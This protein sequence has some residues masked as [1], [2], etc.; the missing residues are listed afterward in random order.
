MTSQGWPESNPVSSID[1]AGTGVPV[2]SRHSTPARAA[3]GASGAA[4]VGATATLAWL[5]CG[6]D[7]VPPPGAA[8]FDEVA[9]ALRITGDWRW[10]HDSTADG[11]RRRERERW[12]LDRVSLT[13]LRGS[14]LRDVEIELLADDGLVFAC[15][16]RVSY[17][18]QAR[19]DVVGAV[20]ADG[21]EL[22]EVG[23]QVT[24]SP[25]D[26]GLRALGHYH[27]HVDHRGQLVLL[28]DASVA[29][30]T[31]GDGAPPPPPPAIAT[32]LDGAWT[33]SSA[34][35]TADG[36]IQRELERWQLEVHGG[37]VTGSYQRVVTMVR[38]DGVALPCAGADRYQFVDEYQL[39]GTATADGWRLREDAVVAGQHPCLSGYRT[40]TLDEATAALDGEYLIVTWRGPRRQVLARVS[41]TW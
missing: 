31:A 29:R 12:Q 6:P 34:S 30:L 32:T 1:R 2:R 39:V 10:A 8:S 18:Q 23:Y 4:L 22:D 26:P 33:W 40:R 7:P 41:Q 14:Y 17:H 19:F 25:C 5:G 11:S 9:A 28:G 38:P 3:L 37:L 16:Q 24:P 35:W 15:N 20:T 36:L 27:A 21:V 13:R